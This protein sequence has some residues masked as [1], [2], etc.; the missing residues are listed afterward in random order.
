MLDVVCFDP[1]DFGF[2][3]RRGQIFTT[4]ERQNPIEDRRSSE[5]GD[6]FKKVRY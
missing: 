5:I 4:L 1:G 6:Y 3:V 2:C